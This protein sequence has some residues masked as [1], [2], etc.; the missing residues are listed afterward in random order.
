[1]TRTGT[2]GAIAI[3]SMLVL[4]N[5]SPAGA[6][7]S[8][9]LYPSGYAGVNAARANLDVSD[10]GLLYANAVKRSTFLYVHARANE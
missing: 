6:K 4:A 10:P 9:S 2:F 7:G 3:V 8:R 1:M 5:P